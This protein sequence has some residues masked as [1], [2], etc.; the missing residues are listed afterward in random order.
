VEA[1]TRKEAAPSHQFLHS[2]CGSK[3]VRASAYLLFSVS[4]TAILRGRRENRIVTGVTV[5]SRM[6]QEICLRSLRDSRSDKGLRSHGRG[7]F[8]PRRRRCCQCS[9]DGEIAFPSPVA[10]QQQNYSTNTSPTSSSGSAFR[11]ALSQD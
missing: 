4:P 7:S 9:G 5:V 1:A 3:A 6:Y 8:E 11:R 2:P 10:P